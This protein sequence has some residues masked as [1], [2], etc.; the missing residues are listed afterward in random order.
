MSNKHDKEKK[1]KRVQL[2]KEKESKKIKRE[3]KIR[4][5]LEFQKIFEERIRAKRL[6]FANLIRRKLKPPLSYLLC[7]FYQFYGYKYRKFEEFRS[8]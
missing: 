7:L 8:L 2:E 6:N 5:E 4:E 1:V 3:Q